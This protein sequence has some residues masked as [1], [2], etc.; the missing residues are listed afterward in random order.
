MKWLEKASSAVTTYVSSGWGT[1]SALGV[2][3]VWAFATVVYGDDTSYKYVDQL[4]SAVSFLLLFLLQRSQAKDG[5]ALHI[6][7]NELLAAVH[8]AS[9]R[10]AAVRYNQKLWMS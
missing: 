6:K 5:M 10:G 3:A 9:P 8:R 1:L 7:V 4:F 2:I